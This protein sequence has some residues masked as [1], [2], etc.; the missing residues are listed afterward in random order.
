MTSN[1]YYAGLNRRFEKRAARLMS[2]GFEYSSADCIGRFSRRVYGR[3]MVV[4]AASAMHA[5]NRGWRDIMATMFI[6]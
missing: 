5:T 4:T 6:R 2:V 3:D 1:Q